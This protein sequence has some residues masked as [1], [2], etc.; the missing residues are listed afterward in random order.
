MAR[1]R[2]TRNLEIPGSPLS[3]RPGMTEHHHRCLSH[4]FES[5]GK[6]K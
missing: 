3:R 1:E 2:Q 4:D 5:K 6:T